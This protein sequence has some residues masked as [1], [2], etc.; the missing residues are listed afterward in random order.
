MRRSTLAES[1]VTPAVRGMKENNGRAAR[2]M[3][4]RKIGLTLVICASILGFIEITGLGGP[5]SRQSRN[6]KRKQGNRRDYTFG[7]LKRRRGMRKGISNMEMMISGNGHD[8][9]SSSTS[10]VAPQTEKE[11]IDLILSASVHLVSIRKTQQFKDDTY[12]GVIGTFCQ[13]DW[14]LH[15]KDPSAH[16]MFR[17][18]IAHSPSCGGKNQKFDMD[19]KKIATLA[20]NHDAQNQN[21]TSNQRLKQN[22]NNIP[23][24]LSVGGFV[25]HESRCGST[26]TA[27]SLAAMNPSQTRVYS[28]SPPPVNALS[29]CGIPGEPSSTCSI[30]SAA[31]LLRDVVYMMSRTNDDAEEYV[32]FKI[33]SMGTKYIRI[34]L[35]A[36]PTVPWIFVYRDPVQVMMSHLRQ[37][38][39]S[40]NCVRQL[41]DIPSASK[42]YLSSINHH[43]HSLEPEQKCALH[44]STLCE[45]AVSALLTADTGLAVNYSELAERLTFQIIPEHFDIPMTEDMIDNIEEVASKYSKGRGDKAKQWVEDSAAKERQA[46]TQ[47]REA[48]KLFL[49]KSYS[50]LEAFSGY[51]L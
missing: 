28:E 24:A 33:Q 17:D 7:I 1:S 27:N 42:K 30:E 36:F 47:V 6:E 3:Q 41:R 5:S 15:K 18:L 13:I 12:E 2:R 9:G 46:S 43:L 11:K 19:L 26:L 38:L 4:C 23:H 48:A 29:S 40:A 39:T 14:S 51:S 34:F 32:F 50:S 37:G 21:A 35:E 10:F 44:L 25:F 45:S 20:R 31:S 16:P 22:N 8:N 49:S